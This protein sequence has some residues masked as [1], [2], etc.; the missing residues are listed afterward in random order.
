MKTVLKFK[1]RKSD[2]QHSYE[3]LSVVDSMKKNDID[4]LIQNHFSDQNIPFCRNFR[5][6]F[7]I[8]ENKLCLVESDDDSFSVIGSA[9]GLKDLNQDLVRFIIGHTGKGTNITVYGQG[10]IF[11]ILF[12]GALSAFNRDVFAGRTSFD[13]DTLYKVFSFMLRM[14]ELQKPEHLR[15]I[16]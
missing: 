13:Q 9:N 1:H 2:M 12:G 15:R 5:G 6:F 14:N 3:N 7:F 4:V 10:E 11:N 16:G 8:H